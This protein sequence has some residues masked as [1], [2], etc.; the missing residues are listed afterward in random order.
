MAPPQLRLAELLAALSLAIDLGTGQP[1]EWVMQCCLMGVQLAEVLGLD[2]QNRRKVYY[3]SLLR[4]LGC[5][6]AASGVAAMFGS[7]M[8]LQEAFILDSQDFVRALSFM[9]RSAGKDQ[10]LLQ[11]ARY[12]ARV[13]A[14]GPAAKDADDR[15]HCE[16]AVRLAQRL[17]LDTE[18]LD[19]L[20]Q[21]YE[22]WDGR[23]VPNRLKGEQIALPVRVVQ[24]AEV[25]V[26]AQFLAGSDTAVGLL[27]ERANRLYD[28]VLVDAFCGVARDLFLQS[29]TGSLWEMVLHSEPG[30]SVYLSAEHLDN[31]LLAVADFTDLKSPYLVNHSRR[32]ADLAAQAAE[33]CGLPASDVVTVRRAGWIHDIGR[34][35]VSAAIWNKAGALNDSEWER[36]R[37]HPNFTDRIFA[38]SST[39]KPLGALAA[40]HH[41]R[42]DGSGYHRQLPATLLPPTARLLAAADVYAA[43]TEARPHRPMFSFDQAAAELRREARAARL[44]PEIVNAV[45]GAAGHKVERPRR[46]GDLTPREL[47]ILRLLARGLS[48]RQMAQ[49]LTISEKTVGHHVERLYTKIAVSTRAGATLYAVQHNLLD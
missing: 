1:M 8:H 34:V 49:H 5:T 26:T 6:A 44:D 9:I 40:L 24:L 12:L 2:E 10:P 38:R 15:I 36:V 39:L 4:H 11:R 43:L 48:N 16:V 31:A 25:A 21:V 3:L 27:R 47:E 35:G 18:L 30:A 33:Q 41:E 14:A 17:K 45:L 20:G 28:P 42:L 22:R 19:Q 13:M 46:V 37:L 7:E 32:V 29:E 23:G